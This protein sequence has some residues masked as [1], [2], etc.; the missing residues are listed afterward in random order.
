MTD[1]PIPY[2]TTTGAKPSRS[3]YRAAVLKVL[4]GMRNGR[5]TMTLPDGSVVGIGDGENPR[6]SR[7]GLH[8]RIDVKSE[9]FFRRCFYYADIGLAESYMAGE[10]TTDD[11]ADVVSW[12]ILNA[13]EPTVR[14]RTVRRLLNW[15][16][17][18]NR[19]GHRLRSNTVERSRENIAAHYD[20][21]NELFSLFLD[22]TMTYSSGLFSSETDT[23]DEAQQA[24][25]ERLCQLLQLKPGDRVLEIGGGWGA[26]SRYIANRYHCQV[27]TITISKEQYDWA[28]RLRRSENLEHLIDL[29]LLDYRSL[30]GEFD[31][32]V[33]IEMLE[34]VGHEH[35]DAFFGKCSELLAPNGLAAL[36]VITF[37]DSRYE[38]MRHDVDFIQKHV[39]PGGLLPSVS[40][41]LASIGRT[42]DLML[43]DLFEFGPSYAKT[44]QCWA[45][46]FEARL[47]DVRALGFDETFIRKWRYYLM[48]CKAAFQMRHVGVVQMLLTR[49]NNQALETVSA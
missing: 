34:A 29:R 40:A 13:A 21:S 4:H 35:F 19:L 12:F 9:A 43:A 10:W 18:F 6:G 23:L 17:W 25:Y 30:E 1:Y 2:P 16:G 46:T 27:T 38:V 48:Y 24:K 26:M 49:P 44:L 39:F 15:M 20:L 22:P 47:D 45:D 8:A 37:P 11:L 33:S 36:Q 14:A 41:M 3:L 42:G 31:K 28:D 32:I 7:F 5:L